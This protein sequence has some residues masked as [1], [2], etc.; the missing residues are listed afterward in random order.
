MPSLLAWVAL[1]G[2]PRGIANPQAGGGEGRDLQAGCRIRCVVCDV[3]GFVASA[4]KLFGD[5]RRQVRVD[6][7][8]HSALKG[9]SRCSDAAPNASAA[10]MSSG[11]KSG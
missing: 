3:S 1:S 6:Q 11:S 8:S 5:R 10:K 7:K 2:T 9:T 4:D